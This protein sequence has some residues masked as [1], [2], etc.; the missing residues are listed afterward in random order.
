MFRS[1]VNNIFALRSKSAA[2]VKKPLASYKC[3]S[4]KLLLALYHH[5]YVLCDRK[6]VADSKNREDGEE[7][8]GSSWSG[9]CYKVELHRHRPHHR[10]DN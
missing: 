1:K 9:P 10:Y 7:R 8:R 3:L 2:E 5:S 4:S 6:A